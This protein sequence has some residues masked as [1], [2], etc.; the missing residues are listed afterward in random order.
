MANTLGTLIRVTSFG[1][2]HGGGV[3]VVIDGCPAGHRIS[4]ER[5]QNFLNRRRPGQSHLASPRDEKDQVECLSGLVDQVSL[6]TPITLVVRN[7]DAK[8]EHYSDLATAYRPSHADYTTDVK[9]GSKAPSGGGRASARETI[10]RVAAAAVLE[11][12]LEDLIPNFKVV[13]YVDQVKHIQAKLESTDALTRKD[14]DQTPL[15]CPDINV[16][17]DMEQLIIQ[18]KKSGDSVGGT[19]TCNIVGCP[20]GIGE[21]VFDKLEADL[22]KAMMSL[23]ASRG[24]EIGSGFSSVQY[25]GS[26]HNDAFYQDKGR[27]RTRTNRS[28]GVQGGISN[29]E[30]IYFRVAFKPVATVF[31]DQETVNRDG[32]SLTMKPKAGRHDPCVLPRAVPMVEAMAILVVA[33]HYFRQ[34]IFQYGKGQERI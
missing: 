27:V 31:K 33:D 10:G 13:A 32:E 18:A 1:E 20:P 2:S 3:G 12:I 22:A 34:F 11:Q 8:K 15:R 19:I 7:A 29:G 5:I 23:P 9:Y 17:K 4:L 14:V 16:Q 21:P 30:M 26:E 24:F 28:G 25:F 6:G